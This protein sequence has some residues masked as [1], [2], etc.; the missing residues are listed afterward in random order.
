MEII[1]NMNR[2]SRTFCSFPRR[3]AVAPLCCRKPC[4]LHRSAFKPPASLPS[5]PMSQWRGYTTSCLS[6]KPA[7]F[8]RL[9]HSRFS[10][11]AEHSIRNSTTFASNFILS[12]CFSG[13]SFS[14]LLRLSKACFCIAILLKLPTV[15]TKLSSALSSARPFILYLLFSDWSTFLST[16][17]ALF[18]SSLT[19]L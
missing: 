17:F 5:M 11:H 3:A 19:N 6:M 7:N 14:P 1:I 12:L 15:C 18:S 2:L 16:T 8:S 4:L 13:T 10:I 9:S